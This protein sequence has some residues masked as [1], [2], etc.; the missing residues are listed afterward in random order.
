MLAVASATPVLAG[1]DETPGIDRR[2]QRQE[3]RIQDGVRSGALT[4]REAAKLEAEQARIRAKEQA[5][6]A[7]GVVT[8][9]ERKE[10]QRD[11]D[12]SSR[13]IAREKHDKQGR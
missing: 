9:G 6:K 2:E 11:L 7:D 3:E 12:R 1:P 13:H 5:M 8:R 4:P 10:L